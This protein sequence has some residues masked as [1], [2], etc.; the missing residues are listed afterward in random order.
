MK[1]QHN[2]TFA[3]LPIRAVAGLIDSGLH[4]LVFLYSL[5]LIAGI[6]SLPLLLPQLITTLAYIWLPLALF[7]PLML[8]ILLTK[9]GF[10]PGKYLCG[11]YLCDNSGSKLTF[12]Q[13]VFREMIGKKVSG[14]LLMLGF[15]NI[16]VDPNHQAWHDYFSHSYVKIDQN[17]LALGAI[18]AI[19]ILAAEIYLG[20]QI[21]NTIRANTNL[22]ADIQFL[23]EPLLQLINK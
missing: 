16:A 23:I 7:Y 14:A 15:L 2:P 19:S 9:T 3:N 5:L 20:I 12:K 13:V 21:G 8:V 22:I 4:S 11:I 1:L 17:R 10:T 6:S 18:V